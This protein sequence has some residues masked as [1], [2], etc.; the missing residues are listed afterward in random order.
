M[1]RDLDKCKSNARSVRRWLYH[2]TAGLAANVFSVE[3]C[4]KLC[5]DGKNYAAVRML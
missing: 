5:G 4:G 3:N 1:D 2:R